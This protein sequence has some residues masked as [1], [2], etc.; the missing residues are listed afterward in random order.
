MMLLRRRTYSGNKQMLDG[1]VQVAV[2]NPG[3]IYVSYD[4]GQSWKAVG[5]LKNYNGCAVSSTGQYMLACAY[6]D[7]IYRSEDYG[8]TWTQTGPQGNYNS[9][10]IS[11]TGQY[12]IACSGTGAYISSD[13][14]QTWTQKGDAVTMFGS[15]ISED[16]KYI[17]AAASY[18]GLW[19]SSDFGQT[20][21]KIGNNQN[22]GYY[23]VALSAS[24]ERQIY[25]PANGNGYIYLS[26]DY[27]DNFSQVSFYANIRYNISTSSDGK[28]ILIATDANAKVSKDYGKTFDDKGAYGYSYKLYGSAISGSGKYMLLANSSGQLLRSTDNGQYFHFVGEPTD[29]RAV[30]INRL[31]N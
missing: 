27:G 29:W 25:S 18:R 16:G 21:T 30:A 7:Y 9:C 2:A 19:G 4:F 11:S 12:A 15:A 24:G 6:G 31:S 26:S 8:K 28:Y 3:N 5:E 20:L 14:G 17:L 23:S 22:I 10:A 13:F 1:Q